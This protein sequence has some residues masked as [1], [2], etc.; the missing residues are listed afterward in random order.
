MLQCLLL[1]RG[2]FSLNDTDLKT[3]WIHVVKNKVNMSKT[4]SKFIIRNNIVAKSKGF[5]K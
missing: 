4:L 1:R 5:F 2:L 3:N